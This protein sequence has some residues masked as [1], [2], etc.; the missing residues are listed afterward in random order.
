MFK[1]IKN[2]NKTK[3]IS[4]QLINMFFADKSMLFKTTG[5]SIMLKIYAFFFYI[6]VQEFITHHT[7]EAVYPVTHL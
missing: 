1:R 2:R 3:F 4:H 6:P 7:L 5:V